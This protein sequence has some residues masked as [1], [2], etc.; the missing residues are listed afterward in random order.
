MIWIAAV[1]GQFY[2]SATK[3]D[4]QQKKRTHTKFHLRK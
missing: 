1:A 2:D 3:T 4:Q